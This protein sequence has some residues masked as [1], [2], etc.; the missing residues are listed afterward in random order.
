MFQAYLCL[1]E[2]DWDWNGNHNL[3]WKIRTITLLLTVPQPTIQTIYGITVIPHHLRA[4]ISCACICRHDM[5][6]SRSQIFF[7]CFGGATYHQPMECPDICT[8]EYLLMFQQPIHGSA[9]SYL[10]TKDTQIYLAWSLHIL[11]SYCIHNR[12]TSLFREGWVGC[13]VGP[14]YATACGYP[15]WASL[16]KVSR[17][18]PTFI[19]TYL[20]HLQ[21]L[22]HFR[23]LSSSCDLH[24]LLSKPSFFLSKATSF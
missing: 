13:C 21:D 4:C 24:L 16:V 14:C 10:G 2:V 20:P 19:S 6:K 23:D 3:L 18:P 1:L 7:L 5:F 11:C 9:R 22:L 17:H 8:L 15:S 12:S